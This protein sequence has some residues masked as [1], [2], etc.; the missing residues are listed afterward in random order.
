[1]LKSTTQRLDTQ[2]V[3]FEKL[4]IRASLLAGH[5]VGKANGV[6]ASRLKEVIV[7]TYRTEMVNTE[8][9]RHYSFSIFLWWNASSYN[10]S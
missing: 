8:I 7:L 3:R 9:P 1:M 5:Q 10:Q 4:K 6:R 2:I